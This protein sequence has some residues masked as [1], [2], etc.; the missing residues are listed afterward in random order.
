VSAAGDVCPCCRPALAA[1]ESDR[2]YLAWRTTD[3]ENVRDLV[4]AAS[5]DRGTH[6]SAAR[7]VPGP[8]WR[9]DGCPHSGPS[10][11]V[12][13]DRLF[14]AWYTEATGRSRL[15]WSTSSDGGRSFSPAED[16]AGEILD[17]NHPHLAVIDGRP[18]VT[19]Q[20]RDPVDEGS[21]GSS[22][23]FVRDLGAGPG[24]GPVSL[25]AGPGSASYPV[26]SG[27]GAGRLIVAWTDSSDSGSAIL[28]ARGRI[29]PARR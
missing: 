16:V 20:G 8:S 13:G 17:P 5:P 14:A 25:P 1:D 11:E 7:A 27:L 10:L 3:E 12:A 21:W 9:I 24:A 23:P 6:W 2:W 26:L 4:I 22:R 15:Y 18:F 28:A 29:A 19:F